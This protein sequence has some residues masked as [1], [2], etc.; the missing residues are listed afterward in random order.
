MK[1]VVSKEIKDNFLYRIVFYD[2]IIL[3]ISISLVF[4]GIFR[5]FKSLGE[6]LN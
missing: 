3:T 5:V 2:P 1:I 4:A 6:F